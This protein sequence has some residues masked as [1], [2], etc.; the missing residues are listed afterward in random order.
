MI[1]HEVDWN[2]RI[3]D[4]RVQSFSYSGSS[5]RCQVNDQ[6]YS[7]VSCRST[8]KGMNGISFPIL[9]DQFVSELVAWAA[10]GI[11]LEKRNVFSSRTLIEYGSESGSYPRSCDLML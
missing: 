9:V 5:H 10:P 11:M 4:A 2:F 8:R 3:Y 1:Y 7:S 6:R